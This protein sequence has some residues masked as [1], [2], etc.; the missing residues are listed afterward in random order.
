MLQQIAKT[1]QRRCGE[2]SNQNQK[3]KTM[4]FQYKFSL[5]AVLAIVVMSLSACFDDP[6]WLDENVTTENKH[7]PVIAGF[8]L[9]TEADGS[10]VD[11]IITYDTTIVEDLV[12]VHDTIVMNDTITIVDSIVVVERME[13]DT[14][15]DI[16]DVNYY[17]AGKSLEFDVDY[18]STDPIAA[19]KLHETEGDEHTE[20]VFSASHTDNF[21][22][23]SQTDEMLIA[24]TAPFILADTIQVRYDAEIVN[25]NG[26]TRNTVDGGTANRPS[27]TITV[28]KQ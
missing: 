15:S 23:D 8:Q 28:I 16:F 7:F 5:V 12:V 13:I 25:E 24:H 9:L 22:E 19:I 3:K 4:N 20:E 27:I 10:Y 2:I 11:T 21:Q 6:D 14:V 17:I 18:W 1:L 26:L